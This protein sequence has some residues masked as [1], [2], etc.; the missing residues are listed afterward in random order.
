MDLQTTL[1]DLYDA[2]LRAFGHRGWWPG[3]TPLEVMVGAILT[4]RTN[5]RNA[6]TAIDALRAAGAL[7]A[8]SL[9]C[10]DVARLQELIRPAGY[11]RQK[12]VRL[13]RLARWL[14]ENADGDPAALADVSTPELREQL[15]GLRGIGPETA[16]SIL[17]YALERPVFVVDT[18]T[19]RVA[20]RHQLVSQE[21][22]YAELQELFADHLPEDVALF[23]DY[24]AQLVEVGK[25]FCR[26]Q[27][28]CLRCPVP[29]VLG[30]PVLDDW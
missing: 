5:W 23:K 13:A 27:P 3:E 8:Q 9:A 2:L 20:V 7:D 24:H 17:L 12:S 29:A 14:V 15:L 21:C 19:M 18:Y 16:D 11:Y 25:R 6:S 28:R 22:G 10:M 1:T 4:Q 30:E 26:P